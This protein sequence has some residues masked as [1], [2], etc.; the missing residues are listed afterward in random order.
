MKKIDEQEM[1][2]EDSILCISGSMG[3]DYEY[4]IVRHMTPELLFEKVQEYV[5]LEETGEIQPEEQSMEEYLEKQGAAVI[6]VYDSNG[7]GEEKPVRFFDVEYDVDTG[8]RLFIDLNIQEQVEMLMEKA[9]YIGATLNEEDKKWIEDYAIKTGNITDTKGLIEKILMEDSSVNVRDR[10]LAME[11]SYV[12]SGQEAYYAIFQINE[13]TKGKAYRFM[14]MDYAVSHG[15]RI[16]ASDYNFVY[17]GQMTE[18]DTLDRLYER[19]NIEHPKDY[20]GHSLSVSDVIVLQEEQRMKA[21]YVDSFGYRELP[22]FLRQRQ[23]ML[24]T[25]SMIKNRTGGIAVEGHFG[26]WHTVE[27]REI[28]GESFFRMEHDEYGNTVAGIIVNADGKLVAEDLEHGF[29]DGAME[30]ITEYL[31][32]KML[33]P[34]IKQFYV[35]NDAYG[36]K[37]EREYQYFE[38]LDEAIQAYHLLPNHL[39]KRL[40]MESREPV[41]S[42]MTLLKCENGIENVEDI[43]SA[44]L[45]G[46]WVNPEVTDAMQKAQYYLDNRDME[47]A[48]WIKS[49][50]QYFFIQTAAEGYDYTFYDKDYRALDGGIYDNPDVSEQEAVEDILSGETGGI[51]AGYQVVNVEE[52][53][54]NVAKVQEQEQKEP[55]ISF[56]AAECMEFPVMGE[57]HDN[58]TLEEAF[59]KYKEIPLERM[60]GIKGIGF[61]LEDGSMYDGDYELM[62]AGVISKDMIDLVPHYKESPL[63][64]KAVSDLEQM[65]SQ[66]WQRE[67][68]EKPEQTEPEKTPDTK[69]KT[70]GVRQSVLAALRERQAKQK[71]QE[72]KKITPGRKKGEAVL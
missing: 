38:N 47:T 10:V 22:D 8:I 60:N 9:E 70:V 54:E 52:F 49:K 64:Q 16:D 58:L 1:Q 72:E 66:D 25:D 15:M 34:F 61:R 42:R 71:A 20:T 27:V 33:E 67:Q 3:S 50:N 51:F 7:L 4:C 53:L 40:G 65:L 19:F 12:L 11:E 69:E 55:S 21:Y 2:W 46:K 23:E 13:D 44:S 31:Y 45:N 57:Y 17:S 36:V 28:A 5:R 32:E 43:E 41:T 68:A 18:D 63:V 14:G 29:D 59:Q 56:Y 26:T 35:V 6:P 48:Y 24:N 37:A 39:D 30:A 62:R